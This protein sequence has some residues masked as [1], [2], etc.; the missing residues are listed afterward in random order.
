MVFCKIFPSFWKKKGF[1]T[2]TL[3]ECDLAYAGALSILS[4][5]WIL[6]KNDL[7][8][9]YKNLKISWILSNVRK[10]WKLP[11]KNI[12][13]ARH[14]FSM[15]LISIKGVKM[16]S[17]IIS[18]KI[19]SRFNERISTKMD[20]TVYRLHR[21]HPTAWKLTNVSQNFLWAA[22]KIQHFL[23]WEGFMVFKGFSVWT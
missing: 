19:W 5:S 22:K 8:N 1:L 23:S 7:K 9:L 15:I 17:R 3:A 4:C 16:K 20:F 2:P 10:I 12:F 14:C 11:R 13:K 18:K 6:N 21:D